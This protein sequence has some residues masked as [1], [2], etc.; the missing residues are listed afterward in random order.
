MNDIMKT[1]AED[2]GI[3][4]QIM[5]EQAGSQVAN[6][7]RERS[8]EELKTAV[9]CG[10]GENGASGLVAARRLI[11]WG[12]NIEVYTPFEKNTLTRTTRDKLEDVQDMAEDVNMLDLPTANAYVDALTGH[13]QKS[14][15]GKVA[16]S[17]RKISKWSAHTTSVDVPSGLN[18]DTGEAYGPHVRPDS[19][20]MLGLPKKGLNKENSGDLFLADIG[21]PVQAVEQNNVQAPDFKS[22]SLI[23]IEE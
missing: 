21:I 19:T 14:L 17:V 11:S 9:I 1:A 18:S 2:Y 7:V 3:S 5:V 20:V 15:R 10:R 6:L 4:T 23:Q 16:E 8:S 12:Y 22:K 13:C